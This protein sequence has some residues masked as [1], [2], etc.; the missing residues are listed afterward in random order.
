MNVYVITR[1]VDIFL[2]VTKKVSEN[3]LYLE[4]TPNYLSVIIEKGLVLLFF[5]KKKKK[6]I[7]V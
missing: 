3:Q 5:F 2:L 4:I 6:Y 1:F 7:K